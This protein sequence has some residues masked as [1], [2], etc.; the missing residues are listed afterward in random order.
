MGYQDCSA[1]QAR[2]AQLRQEH[3]AESNRQKAA[4]KQARSQATE[5]RRLQRLRECMRAAAE[6]CI[7]NGIPISHASLRAAGFK[8]QT[9]MMGPLINELIEDGT[10]QQH[11]M[12]KHRARWDDWREPEY[13]PPK[14]DVEEQRVELPPLHS[15]A[16]E[17]P[18]EH[19]ARLEKTCSQ[20]YWTPQRRAWYRRQ[21]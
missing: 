15:H 20:L 17:V 1:V 5:A 11:H 6:R 12:N 4:R 19:V 9:D 10:V 13:H 16:P 7:A 2:H 8:G 3:E 21:A 18:P 14:V